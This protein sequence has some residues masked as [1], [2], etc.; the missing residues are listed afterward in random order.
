MLDKGCYQT[1][2]FKE[3]TLYKSIL[4]AVDGSGTSNLAYQEALKLA[5]ALKSKLSIVHVV[6]L[7]IPYPDAGFVWLDMEKYR[8]SHR[9]IG[10]ELLTKMEANASKTGVKVETKLLENSNITRISDAIITYAK[11]SN[12]D[13]MVLGTHGRMGFHRFLIGSVAEEAVRTSTI[14]VLLVKEPEQT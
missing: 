13:L 6:D 8:E 4:V 5:E 10:L 2:Q 11:K 1:E 7:S 12:A 9:K 14:P 3:C